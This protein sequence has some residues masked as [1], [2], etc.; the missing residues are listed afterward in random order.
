MVN[1]FMFFY[2]ILKNVN[3]CKFRY[4]RHFNQSGYLI[5]HSNC[6]DLDS[7]ATKRSFTTLDIEERVGG[8]EL[9]KKKHKC[10]YRCK[11]SRHTYLG[12]SHFSNGD[13]VTECSTCFMIPWI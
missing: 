7:N 12:S 1:C 6:F 5:H 4:I 8:G 2:L 3:Y 10:K 9:Y 13:C 11:Y